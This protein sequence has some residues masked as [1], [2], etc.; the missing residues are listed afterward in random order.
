MGKKGQNE[1]L[2]RSRR[3]SEGGESKNE[4]RIMVKL[5]V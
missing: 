4:K 1:L 3:E 5:I 2:G